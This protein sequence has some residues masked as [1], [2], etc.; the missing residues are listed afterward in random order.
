[1]KNGYE[2]FLYFQKK[3]L[4]RELGKLYKLDHQDRHVIE[5]YISKDSIKI[6]NIQ[7]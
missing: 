6:L 3:K 1:M 2:T 4:Y 7:A 5:D